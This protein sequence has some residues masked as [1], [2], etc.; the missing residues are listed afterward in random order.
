MVILHNNN[1]LP[2]KFKKLIINIIIKY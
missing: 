1:I 2:P